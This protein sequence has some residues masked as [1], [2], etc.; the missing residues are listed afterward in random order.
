M[1]AAIIVGPIRTKQMQIDQQ[2]IDLYGNWPA[3][4]PLCCHLC[5]GCQ[6]CQTCTFSAKQQNLCQ[7]RS[8]ENDFKECM[9]YPIWVA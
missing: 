1:L 6:F 4:L 5:C 3:G 8:H 7:E 2:I 9:E